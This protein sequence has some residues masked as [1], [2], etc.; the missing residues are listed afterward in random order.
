[1]RSGVP[2]RADTLVEWSSC[3]REASRYWSWPHRTVHLECSVD[4]VV[5]GTCASCM[6]GF[7]RG[8]LEFSSIS[9]AANEVTKTVRQLPR[10]CALLVFA[11]LHPSPGSTRLH[12]ACSA[13]QPLS[14]APLGST[15]L[16]L[17]PLDSTRLLLGS[18]RLARLHSACSAPLGSTRIPFRPRVSFYS[19]KKRDTKTP[20][21]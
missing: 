5:C 10:L 14:S 15:R 2:Y 12:S 17:A 13:P 1:M 4:N 9:P 18:T 3:G 8:C 6:N 16:H 11:R 20:N 21:T 19:T 7:L